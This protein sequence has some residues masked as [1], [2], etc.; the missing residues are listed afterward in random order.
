MRENEVNLKKENVDSDNQCGGS[1]SLIE[2]L[3]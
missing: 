3:E 2:V 1:M